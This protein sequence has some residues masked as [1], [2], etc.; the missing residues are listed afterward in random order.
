LHKKFYEDSLIYFKI[1]CYVY[2]EQYIETGCLINYIL[3]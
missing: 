2:I 1:V 3:K